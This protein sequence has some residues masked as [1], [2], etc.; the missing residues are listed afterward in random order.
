MGSIT[1]VYHGYY[2]LRSLRT[3]TGCSRAGIVDIPDGG[4]D[5]ECL[6]SNLKQLY[7]EA[8]HRYQLGSLQY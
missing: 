8:E 4:L 5:I 6:L 3:A 2:R 1:G 7:I